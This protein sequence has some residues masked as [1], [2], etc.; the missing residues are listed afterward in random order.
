MILYLVL[1]HTV[2]FVLGAF[3]GVSEF[4]KGYKEGKQKMKPI[5]DA[6]NSLCEMDK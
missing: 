6:I 5:K 2:L 4:E 3:W 1:S